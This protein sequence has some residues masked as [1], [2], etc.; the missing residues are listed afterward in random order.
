MSGGGVGVSVVTSEAVGKGATVA[1]VNRG[2]AIR[3]CPDVFSLL[4]RVCVC[5]VRVRQQQPAASLF[6]VTSAESNISVATIEKMR[7][8]VTG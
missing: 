5:D 3:I 2:V 4:V 8:K 6:C 7:N 1:V